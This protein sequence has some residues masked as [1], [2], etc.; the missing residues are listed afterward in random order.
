MSYALERLVRS[1]RIFFD[2]SVAVMSA[3]STVV[4]LAGLIISV[5]LMSGQ[6]W[7]I[8]LGATILFGVVTHLRFQNLRSSR[9]SQVNSFDKLNN[10]SREK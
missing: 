2:W 1:F 6:H 3:L 5:T 8:Y 10:V 4:A 7:L 9:G